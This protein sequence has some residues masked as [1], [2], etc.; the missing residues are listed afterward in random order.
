MIWN[1]QLNSLWVYHHNW[2]LLHT[3]R[4]V[5]WVIVNVDVDLL[6]VAASMKA[7]YQVMPPSLHS[8]KLRCRQFGQRFS[9]FMLVVANVPRRTSGLRRSGNISCKLRMSQQYE[10]WCSL[11]YVLKYIQTVMW[12]EQWKTWTKPTEQ[13]YK[14]L[15]RTEHN[16]FNQ[17]RDW[18]LHS[19]KIVNRLP[20]Q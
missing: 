18:G 4:G 2:P 13:V 12:F 16:D 19:P 11:L 1:K 15:N 9:W 6:I 3:V 17:L 7:L 8:M 10:R 14:S 20:M 5:I